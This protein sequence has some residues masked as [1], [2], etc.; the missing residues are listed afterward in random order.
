MKNLKDGYLELSAQIST[1]QSEIE[2]EPD[3]NKNKELEKEKEKLCEQAG[4]ISKKLRLW[5]FYVEGKK[6]TLERQKEGVEEL[7]SLLSN[8]NMYDKYLDIPNGCNQE[9]ENGSN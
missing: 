8:I 4:D 2:S 6:S 9:V 3:E 7:I 5:K 1:K